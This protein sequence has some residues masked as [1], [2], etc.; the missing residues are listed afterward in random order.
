[1]NPDSIAGTATETGE[2]MNAGLR[3]AGGLLDNFIFSSAMSIAFFPFMM[4]NLLASVGD[5]RLPEPFPLP[6]FIAGAV[7]CA[8]F[9]CK[10]VFNGR[11]P[12][13]RIIKMQVVDSRTGLPAN[14]LR[15]MVRNIPL[16]FWPME[17]IAVL[18]NP[19]KR[20]G[21]YLAGT[22]VEYTTSPQRRP[23]NPG[24]L[25]LAFLIALACCSLIVLPFYYLSQ[26]MFSFHERMLHDMNM[27]R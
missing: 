4:I 17:G 9:L 16:L 5:N 24:Q 22:Q 6:F 27:Y 15:C 12:A 26:L 1:M 3:I 20:V 7:F 13:K 19:K 14:P 2:R 23:S 8:L 11:S 25:F 21:D 18:L 10:D